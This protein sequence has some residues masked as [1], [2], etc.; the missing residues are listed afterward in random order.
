MAG[1]VFPRDK[2]RGTVESSGRITCRGAA[3]RRASAVASQAL[4]SMYGTSANLGRRKFAVQVVSSRG[5]ATLQYIKSPREKLWSPR[6]VSRRNT[7]RPRAILHTPHNAPERG[8]SARMHFETLSKLGNCI[9]SDLYLSVLEISLPSLSLAR[10][11]V[12]SLSQCDATLRISHDSTSV[13]E[14]HRGDEIF[15]KRGSSS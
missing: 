2:I 11:L 6:G 5:S 9:K 8:V 1:D 4:F 15:D 14:F 12:L 7:K 13:V 10:S 3:M